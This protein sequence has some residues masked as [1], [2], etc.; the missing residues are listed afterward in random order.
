MIS[1]YI[2]ITPHQFLDVC[3]F[4][5]Q[6]L[7]NY[8][9]TR[10]EVNIFNSSIFLQLMSMSLPRM[11]F[12]QNLINLVFFPGKL[13]LFTILLRYSINKVIFYIVN[14]I[15]VLRRLNQLFI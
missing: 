8:W 11:H 5:I 4:T 12:F 14:P 6:L 15:L 1:T 2:H 7:V 9:W 13:S 10:L 3:I